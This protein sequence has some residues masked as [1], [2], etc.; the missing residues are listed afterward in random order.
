[1]YFKFILIFRFQEKSYIDDKFDRVEKTVAM[2]ASQNDEKDRRNELREE[3]QK[4]SYTVQSVKDVLVKN[5]DK[6]GE[7][8]MKIENLVNWVYE[9]C[10][11]CILNC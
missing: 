7:I 4:L 6:I 10:T 2:I 11:F 9:K 8:V 5:D 3:F 1:M